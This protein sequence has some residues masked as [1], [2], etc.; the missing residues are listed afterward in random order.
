[1]TKDD[2][3]SAKDIVIKCQYTVPKGALTNHTFRKFITGDEG[4]T[5][6]L[7]T[8]KEVED[9]LKEMDITDYKK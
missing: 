9:F 7:K 4:E 1:M 3:N 5:K 8:D 6:E 2:P